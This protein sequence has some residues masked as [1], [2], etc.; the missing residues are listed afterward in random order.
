MEK[1]GIWHSS[2]LKYKNIY[3]SFEFGS[4]DIN[5]NGNQLILIFYRYIDGKNIPIHLHYFRSNVDEV[6]QNI[7]KYLYIVTVIEPFQFIFKIIFGKK[8][9]KTCAR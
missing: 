5:K 4:Y 6:I 1:C 7:Y 3:E 9:K 8:E 2:G